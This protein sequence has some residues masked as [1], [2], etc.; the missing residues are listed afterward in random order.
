MWSSGCSARFEVVDDGQILALGGPKQR[1]VLACSLLEAGRV[2]PRD[3]II[4]GVWGETA[5]DTAVATVQVYVCILR[6][7]LE[8][9]KGEH[10]VLLGRRPGYLLRGRP[11]P[12]R[13]PP[14]RA[15]GRAR[16]A[17]SSRDER[18]EAAAR[19]LGTALGCGAATPLADL[20]AAD[21]AGPELDPAAG[22]CAS[23]QS[24]TGSRPSWPAAGTGLSSPSSRRW[25]PSTRC[26]E[27]LWGQ[28][29]LALYRSG[30]QAE[31]LAAYGRARETLVDEYG[32]DPGPDLRELERRILNQDPDLAPPPGTAR[33]TVKLPAPA[34]RSSGAPA[35]F[36]AVCRRTGRPH[37]W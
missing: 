22:D 30:Q 34:I 4:D 14:L 18:H 27:R 26:G 1:A 20:E 5:A 3:R 21:F 10:Q 17:S 31:A 8:P 15:P 12:G 35:D 11:G 37:A 13:C 6:K 23:A 29:M 7:V 2:V 24:R 16:R 28:L 36:A 19:D 32:I 25:S 9:A 33:V